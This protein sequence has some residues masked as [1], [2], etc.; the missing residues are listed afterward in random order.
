MKLAG[1]KRQQSA[2][3]F[4]PVSPYVRPVRRMHSRRTLP[5]QLVPQSPMSN[6]RSFVGQSL[7]VRYGTPGGSYEDLSD[8]STDYGSETGTYTYISCMPASILK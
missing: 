5:F 8:D 4:D 3:F 1:F 6:S 7:P 2:A